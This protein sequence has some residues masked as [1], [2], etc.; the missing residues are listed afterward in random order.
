MTERKFASYVGMN[1]LWLNFSQ[2]KV[3]INFL[4]WY[5]LPDCQI[6]WTVAK[7]ARFVQPKCL[8]ACL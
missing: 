8:R 2:V 3:C 6:D 5:K 1:G 7:V 4:K